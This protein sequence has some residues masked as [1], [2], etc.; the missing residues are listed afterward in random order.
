MDTARDRISR[1]SPRSTIA[2]P[3][4]VGARRRCGSTPSRS[5]PT[6]CPWWRRVRSPCRGWL[7]F[8]CR[9]V[10]RPHGLA[11]DHARDRGTP[12][13]RVRR[14]RSCRK[15]RPQLAFNTR[16]GDELSPSP[17]RR[18]SRAEGLPYDHCPF[19]QI[20]NTQLNGIVGAPDHAMFFM[21][22][23]QQTFLVIVLFGELVLSCPSTQRAGRRPTSPGTSIRPSRTLQGPRR[24]ASSSHARCTTNLRSPESGI[25]R[26]SVQ[27]GGA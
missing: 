26:R 21:R 2:A 10:W 25:R 22:G 7:S 27:P 17:A 3:L 6:C 4:M 1:A 23:S 15:D 5:S 8:P 12:M 13:R 19:E 14:R 16:L 24:G 20:E 9:A 18:A 11:Q